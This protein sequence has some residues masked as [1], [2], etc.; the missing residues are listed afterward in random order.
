MTYKHKL[1]PSSKKFYCPKCNQKRFVKFVDET[2]A[3]LPSKYGR[4]D[5]IIKCTY[6]NKPEN[7]DNDTF[8]CSPAPAK[9]P[10]PP[11][12]IGRE[13]FEASMSRYEKNSLYLYLIKLYNEIAV[14]SAFMRY[15]VGTANLWGGSTVF[16]QMDIQSNLRTGKIMKYDPI[17]G[18]RIKKPKTL[19]TWVHSLLKLKAFNLQQ[20]LFG[21]HLLASAS[22]DDI[23]CIVESEKTAIICSIEFPQFIWLATGSFQMFK[24]ETMHNLKGRQVIVFP[25]TDT[26]H[27][28]V[29]R[30]SEIEKSINIQIKVSDF[31]L[32]ETIS[33]DN[34]FGYDLADVFTEKLIDPPK[35]ISEVQKVLKRMIKKNPALQTLI[36]K[37]D[38]DTENAT[39][40]RCD[41]D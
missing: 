39:L 35:L 32:N 9:P 28:W 31:I 24:K 11:S 34:T 10:L 5:R 29:Q 16:W 17:S 4:C 3:Y 19:I 40:T 21:E 41:S 12:L 18:N 33:K 37:L 22:K 30:A 8:V 15:N 2:G 7:D 27:N 1:D 36:E 25:D 26:H 38:L 13:I 23:F 6:F 14:Q 20:V